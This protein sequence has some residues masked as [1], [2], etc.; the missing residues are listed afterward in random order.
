MKEKNSANLRFPNESW[1]RAGTK[2]F[3]SLVKA[4]GLNIPVLGVTTSG[5]ILELKG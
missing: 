1:V 2:L 3:L 4:S 5:T